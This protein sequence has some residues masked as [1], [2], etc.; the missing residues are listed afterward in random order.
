MD[1]P[2]WLTEARLA[3]LVSLASAAFSGG[4]FIYTRRLAKNDTQKMKRKAP[5]LEAR[6]AESEHH[7]GWQRCFVVVRNLEPVSVDLLEVAVRSKSM[8]ILLEAEEFKTVEGTEGRKQARLATS[9]LALKQ[10]VKIDERLRPV[11]ARSANLLGQGSLPADTESLSFLTQG[12]RSV[13][14]LRLDWAWAD[15]QAR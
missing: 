6:F 14:D 12:V 1:W 9:E 13:R 4:Q 15:G 3:I 2:T 5:V 11:G 8:R 10:S 7:E